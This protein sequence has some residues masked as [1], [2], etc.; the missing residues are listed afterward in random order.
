M[1]RQRGRVERL[2][3][4]VGFV[5]AGVLVALIIPAW[6]DY[7]DS[8]PTE[9]AQFRAAR[10]T[11]TRSLPTPPT[12]TAQ[13]AETL[14]QT[15]VATKPAA[16]VSLFVFAASRGDS[17]LSVH[18]HSQ[19]GPVV[20]EGVLARGKALRVKATRLWIRFGAA[21]NLEVTMNG[22]AVTGLPR[23]TVNMI[24]SS[25]GFRVARKQ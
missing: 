2:L 15:P 18:D 24:A 12:Q 6:L 13:Q 1:R 21:S 3:P 10:R 19:S 16:T 23:G 14:A 25:S 4:W 11:V 9:T 5:V 8:S 17:W 20:Y 7:R 22:R